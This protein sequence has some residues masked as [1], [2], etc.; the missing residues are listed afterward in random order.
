MKCAGVNEVGFSKEHFQQEDPVEKTGWEPLVERI[1]TIANYFRSLEGEKTQKPKESL[2]NCNRASSSESQKK[3]IDFLCKK[4]DTLFPFCEKRKEEKPI[5]SQEQKALQFIESIRQAQRTECP[6]LAPLDWDK[7][8]GINPQS[9]LKSGELDLSMRCRAQLISAILPFRNKLGHMASKELK[10]FASSF[11]E[12]LSDVSY[13][14][15]L[16]FFLE[17]RKVSEDS[18]DAILLELQK[19]LVS[20]MVTLKVE[21]NDFSEIDEDLLNFA[22]SSLKKIQIVHFPALEN[23]YL[24][25]RDRREIIEK[26]LTLS[27]DSLEYVK[28]SGDLFYSTMSESLNLCPHLH[29]VIIHCYNWDVQEVEA[30]FVS[31]LKG[32]DPRISLKYTPAHEHHHL[33]KS[34]S[35][36]PKLELPAATLD[37]E[38]FK[39]TC[40]Y[41]L[42]QG[43]KF[44]E[45]NQYLEREL[46]HSLDLSFYENDPE[47]L[48]D[49]FYTELS[50]LLFKHEKELGPNL[51]QAIADFISLVI[52]RRGPIEKEKKNL[53]QALHKYG[54]KGEIESSPSFLQALYENLLNSIKNFKE[55][56]SWYLK[57]F[58]SL[59]LVRVTRNSELELDINFSYFC[60]VIYPK[61]LQKAEN[62]QSF[63][64]YHNH[65]T[66]DLMK[67]WVKHPHLKKVVIC[68]HR[69]ENLLQV[70]EKWKK[71]LDKL[72]PAIKVTWKEDELSN[73]KDEKEH[74]EDF[75]IYLFLRDKKERGSEQALR[76]DRI[77]V[78]SPRLIH[79]MKKAGVKR[80]LIPHYEFE[81]P[82]KLEEKWKEELKKL[83]EFTE[84]QWVEI[85]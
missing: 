70:Q 81:E 22:F 27:R 1:D 63:S 57:F 42:E 75:V 30:Q 79:L 60:K 65:L 38:K 67:E 59:N 58:H 37:T 84:I 26:I 82:K 46:I 54:E 49:S 8:K 43:R 15:W 50:D 18:C 20:K 39:K 83:S 64:V 41:F 76:I 16:G 10:K 55:P 47:G 69:G 31:L 36:D 53:L 11:E 21:K 35:V 2:Q 45:N 14:E 4:L 23:E 7:I 66:E 44:S 78:L 40:T 74:L 80:V 34:W 25:K 72:P 32:L 48:G 29:T 9:L 52:P 85:M 56:D 73:F 71:H 33:L 62:I 17:L 51:S 24:S 13:A 77:T 28:L 6:V 12:G 19:S 3:V 5:S 61:L 68:T